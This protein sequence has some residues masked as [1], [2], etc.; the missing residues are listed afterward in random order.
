MHSPG[1]APLL[2]GPLFAPLVIKDEGDSWGTG[3]RSYRD[4]T[5][6][7]RSQPGSLKVVESGPARTITESVMDYKGS[8][9]VLQTIGY[10]DWP[11]IE[12]RMRIDWREE[13][14]MLKL[15]VPTVFRGG[16]LICEIPGGASR[17]P[18]DG[19]EHVFGRWALV[20]GETGRRRTSLAVIGCGPHGL[21]FK[22]GE[23][24]ISVLRSAAYCHERG[25][26][27]AASPAPKFMDQG[28]HKLRFL[29]TAGDAGEVRRSVTALADWLSA[30]P[31]ALAH[32]PLGG[33]DGAKKDNHGKYQTGQAPD[34]DTERFDLLSLDPPSVRLCACKR[35]GDAK[36]LILRL[37]E[38]AGLPTEVRLVLMEPLR[39]I[40]LE[41]RPFE[42][43]TLRVE[44]SGAWREAGLITE[45]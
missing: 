18:G 11:V 14:K 22:D 42:I 29:V 40:R 35:S 2:S 25:L 44:R 27:L 9:I 31:Y 5:D 41:F 20:E 6:R 37:H 17:R 30:P 36:A 28:I 45:T 34:E 10:R 39:V 13:R 3:C 4:V 23:L 32:L 8:R 12:F 1:A 24:R 16:T 26:K 7:F 38:T 43:K 15:A 21:D 33:L 19:E